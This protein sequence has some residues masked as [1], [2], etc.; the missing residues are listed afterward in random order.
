V[1]RGEAANEK[2]PDSRLELVV[3]AGDDIRTLDLPATG[4]LTIGRGEGS[5]V[6]ID[7]PA[8]SRNHALLQLGPQLTIEDLGGQNGTMIRDRAG[9][10]A[11]AETLNVRQLVGRKADLSVGD[12]IL[13]G[14]TCVVVRH[15]PTDDV[16]DLAPAP[17]GVVIRDAAVRAVY[18]EAARIAPTPINVLI[19]GE[20]GVGKEVLARAIH[21]RSH[22]AKGP[23]TGVNCAALSETLLDSE[24]FGHERGA[25]TG[26]LQARAGLFEA[27]AGGTVFL[28]EVGELSAAT[29]GRLLRVLGERVVTRVGSNRAL[30]VDVRVLAA[31]NRDLETDVQS[32]R[33]RE[34]LYFRL[35][36]ATLSVPPLRE[37]QSELQHL[38]ELFVAS[39]CRLIERSELPRISGSAYEILKNHRWPG[40]VRE[41]RNVIERAVILC[42]GNTIL[43]EHLPP[44][45]TR[46][47]ERPTVTPSLA[48]ASATSASPPSADL[49]G[50]Q[51]AHIRDEVSRLA[52]EIESIECAR[53]V[54]TLEQCAGSQAAAARRLGI[55]RGTLIS[56]IEK[57]GIR[58][59]RKRG[60]EPEG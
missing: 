40:N 44:T 21:G 15:R 14:T 38:A 22:R 48:Y 55:S 6:R 29:Q 46:L 58:R 56:R 4:T 13:L 59:P 36:S 28:D 20:T 51:P 60:L 8:V 7:D 1:L 34:D 45:L 41:L 42:S 18:A 57:Y 47:R 3:F 10:S 33:F 5:A 26:A 23:F 12:T 25:F 32:G 35:N 53:I 19:L 50:T 43:P 52:N 17:K 39:A 31:T 9:S 11:A 27:S 24:L 2:S 37:R 30:P 16:P 49:P 54:E